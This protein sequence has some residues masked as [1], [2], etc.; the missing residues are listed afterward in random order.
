MANPFKLANML[1]RCV[2]VC[3]LPT[4]LLAACSNVT[5][6]NAP[7]QHV[8]GSPVIPSQLEAD[9]AMC[10]ARANQQAM[11][12]GAAPIEQAGLVQT[13]MRG[14]MAERGYILTGNSP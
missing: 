3:V 11:E 2:A 6:Q 7:W 14:C 8:D 1:A 10:A 5:R 4:L 12:G 13:G 9:R